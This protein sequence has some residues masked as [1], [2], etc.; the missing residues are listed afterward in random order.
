MRATWRDIPPSPRGGRG[1]GVVRLGLAALLAWSGLAAAG[2]GR[3]L[4]IILGTGS[5]T[6]AR[7]DQ[8]RAGGFIV[9][10]LDEAARRAGLTLEW[11]ARRGLAANTEAL[12]RGEADLLVGVDTPER[13]RA[14]YTTGPWWS[15]ELVALTPAAGPVRQDS[16]L[17]GRRLAVPFSVSTSVE[18]HYAG[19]AFVLWSNA[20]EAANSVC[21]GAA[22]AALL[23]A[24][25][26]RQI[27]L[28]APPAC[29]GF[30]L[31]TV[32]SQ[33]RFEL[34]LISRP[35]VAGAARALKR[36]LDEITADGTLASIAA[37]YPQVSTRHAVR[38]AEAARLRLEQRLWEVGLA[39][40][41]VLVLLGA[42]FT[43]SLFRSRRRLRAA[44]ARLQV[45]LEARARAEAALRDSEARFRALF[46][47]APQTVLAMDHDGV[48]VFA[49]RKCEEMFGQA[50][51]GLIGK[52][53][54]T[55]LPERL[56][57]AFREN[58]LAGKPEAAGLRASGEEFPIEISLGTVET[59]EGLTLA[60][61]GDISE[62]VALQQQLLQAQKLESVGHLA[63]GVAHDFNNLLTVIRGYSQ[64][65]LDGVGPRDDLR[66]PLAEIARASDQAAALTR[67]L[68]MFSRRQTGAPRIISL[69]DLLHNLEKM[70]RRLIGE[71]IELI[72]A[73]DPG[74]AAVR[75]DP[76]HVEQV[77][78][79]LA[80]NARDAMPGGGRLVI[81]TSAFHADA[82]YA[83]EHMGV[84]P[85]DYAA[86]KVTDTGFGMTP[87]VKARIF[88]PFFTTKEQGKG[89]GLG[90]S[91][92][93]GIVKQNEGS[94]FVYSEPGRGTAFRI[95]FPSAEIA[96]RLE[97]RAA[98]PPPTLSGSETILL[99]EDEP[100]VRRFIGEVLRSQGYRVLEGVN[101]RSALEI[102]AAD[103]GPIHLLVSDMVM[104]EVSGPDLARR[105]SELYPAA[106]V[107]FMS[108]Y[109]DRALRP[110]ITEALIEKPVTPST[111][112]RR[113]RETLD[114]RLAGLAVRQP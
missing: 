67:Q 20:V 107:L 75:A 91:T 17:R 35:G 105:F 43:L 77:V 29:Q 99:A 24:M 79:N 23:D 104:P 108:G 82:A 50:P 55:L 4:R 93:Y 16:D 22:D 21:L 85:G 34:C 74:V 84:A 31:R 109:S 54:E 10:A 83:G 48:I 90:L 88:E 110:G 18:E 56:H 32:D 47:S 15:A 101:G 9:N 38:L 100:G 68:L 30:S 3:T 42:A 63:G 49:N 45:D 40:A 7:N 98:G 52:S 70:L 69:N 106:P 76:V 87:E 72:L 86:L 51:E 103:P 39:A 60:F 19:S 27:L 26:L 113:V 111:L 25:D 28:A 114:R 1:A 41:F 6:T 53:A 11:Q 102:A 33:A 73:L 71:D 13:H 58:R 61:I 57:A 89:T 65:A 95:L 44:N 94:I 59:S 62:R 96:R 14:F 112:L 5:S 80:I 97:A 8:T 2:T 81:E 46:D 12:Q 92:V 64:M 37:R 66:E 36:A 78:L